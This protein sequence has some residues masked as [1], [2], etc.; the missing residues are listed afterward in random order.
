MPAGNI[1]FFPLL[2]DGLWKR[3]QRL[4]LLGEIMP[5]LLML[6]ASVMALRPSTKTKLKADAQWPDR[7][8]EGKRK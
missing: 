1:C 8:N 2:N 5:A 6:L 4:M 7:L 3:P